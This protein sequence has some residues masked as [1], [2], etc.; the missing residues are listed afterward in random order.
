MGNRQVDVAVG[1][2]GAVTSVVSVIASVP[3]IVEDAEIMVSTMAV[4]DVVITV[5]PTVEVEMT[6][7]SEVTVVLI[8]VM[9]V[10]TVV[11]GT[12]ILTIVEFTTTVSKVVTGRVRVSVMLLGD[13]VAVAVPNG[14]VLS[15]GSKVGDETVIFP[16]GK[17]SI[18][19]LP[20]VWRVVLMDCVCQ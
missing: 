9:A 19:G 18:G 2:T 17:G 4:P 15:R 20:P 11:V 12:G 6:L 5:V 16:V 3:V 1:S 7:P 8:T 13:S 10:T 14:A